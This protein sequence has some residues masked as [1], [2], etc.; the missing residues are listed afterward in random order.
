MDL[1]LLAAKSADIDRILPLVAAYH[2]FEGIASDAAQRRS[3]VERLLADRTLGGIWLVLA[4]GELA[5]YIAL[6]RGFSIE[7]DGFDAFIDEFYLEAEFR[8]RGIGRIVLTALGREAR[9]CGINAL[10]LEVARDNQRARRLYE[11]AGFAARDR[12]LLMTAVLDE[13][14]D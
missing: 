3:A 11:Q 7:F 9:G 6:C 13:R 5:G 14:E 10:H 1:E 2:A 8:S 12:Y 4:D